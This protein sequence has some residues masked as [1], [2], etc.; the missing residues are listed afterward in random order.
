MFYQINKAL[1]FNILFFSIFT[2]FVFASSSSSIASSSA[3]LSSSTEKTVID[4][5]KEKIA[6]QV[7]Q[8]SRENNKLTSGY[9]QKKEEGKLEILDTSGKILNCTYD[10]ITL[11]QNVQNG[12][13]I[14]V[15]DIAVGD[16]VIVEGFM[17]DTTLSLN[18]VYKDSVIGTIANGNVS[19]IDGVKNIISVAGTTLKST[20]ISATVNTKF[21]RYNTKTFTL[22]KTT[23][24]LLVAGDSIHF[25]AKM[26]SKVLTAQKIIIIPQEY[27]LTKDLS[28][29]STTTSASKSSVKM[30]NSSS[31]K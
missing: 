1:I 3:S 15:S 24:D 7:A 6:T 17:V 23:P 29:S 9:I 16:Y 31:K 21:F 27:L 2:G 11:W 20:D 5:L 10:S 26:V 28:K 25:F 30:S 8:L 4:S 12:K 19:N 14:K 18:T 22:E 13:E